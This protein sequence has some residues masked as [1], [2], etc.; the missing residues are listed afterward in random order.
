MGPCAEIQGQ[1]YFFQYDVLDDG[2]EVGRTLVGE[3]LAI[4]S[5]DGDDVYDDLYGEVWRAACPLQCALC[6]C[7]SLTQTRTQT[8]TRVRTH[9]PALP[10]AATA[11]PGDATCG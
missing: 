1:N 3:A 11:G 10:A 8:R 9:T 5:P 6:G 4:P 7:A 2:R